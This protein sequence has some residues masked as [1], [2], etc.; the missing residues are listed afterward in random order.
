MSYPPI[1]DLQSFLRA[2]DEASIGTPGAEDSINAAMAVIDNHKDDAIRGHC[3]SNG[4]DVIE[5][6]LRAAFVPLAVIPP[7]TP[8]VD[9]PQPSGSQGEAGNSNSQ[10]PFPLFCTETPISQPIS[11]T[12]KVHNA[13]TG[14]GEAGKTPKAKGPQP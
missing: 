7:L 12:P 3:L 2:K 11:P 4:L 14:T 8:S 10:A 9:P 5:A 13:Q 6:I 1:I